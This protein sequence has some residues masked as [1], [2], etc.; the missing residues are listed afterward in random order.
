MALQTRKTRLQQVR[1]RIQTKW[2]TYFMKQV[3]LIHQTG[4]ISQPF[5]SNIANSPDLD[6]NYVTA[7]PE[8]NWPIFFL[9]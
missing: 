2:Q 8:Y 9:Q 3:E 6:F 1:L 5:L 4:N 7:H